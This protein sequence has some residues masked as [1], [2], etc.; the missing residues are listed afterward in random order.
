M[1]PNN[2]NHVQRLF[3]AMDRSWRKLRPWRENRERLIRKY[4]GSHYGYQNSGNIDSHGTHRRRKEI[5]ANLLNQTADAYMMALSANRPRVLVSTDFKELRSFKTTLQTAI[6]HLI[7]ELH[8]EDS[9][10]EIVLNSFFSIGVAKIYSRDIGPVQGAE[11]SW[12]DPGMPF[13][14]SLSLDDW[15]YDT[16]AARWNKIAFAADTYR[17]N[18]EGLLE[19]DRNDPKTVK[20][21]G[22]TTRFPQTHDGETP[23]RNLTTD[24]DSTDDDEIEP[25][26]F[27]MDVWLPENREVVTWACDEDH[28]FGHTVLRPLRVVPWDDGPEQ[29]PYRHLNLAS[30]V[31]DNVM[32]VSPAE[33]LSALH[34]LVNGLMLKSRKQA[35]NQKDVPVFSAGAKDDAGRVTSASDGEFTLVNN[36]LE[37]DVMKFNGADPGTQQFTLSMFDMFDR[38]A[39]NLSA[40]AGLGPQSGTVGQDQLIHAQVSRR[41]AKMQYQVVRFTSNVCTDLGSLLWHDPVREQPGSRRIDGVSFEIDDPWR[42]NERFGDFWQYNFAVEP[43]SMSYKSPTERVASINDL[44]TNIYIPAMQAGLM[45]GE[46]DMQKLLEIHA[47]LLDLPR[48]REIVKI[49]AA[50]LGNE[51]PAGEAPG[52]PVHTKREVI[53]RNIPTGGTDQSRRAELGKALLG[54]RGNDDQ[55]AAM[56]RSRA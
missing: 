5:I 16:Q 42:A 31:P 17:V 34:D 1:N 37:M 11:D 53:R 33:N 18:F 14:E 56:T 43:F 21:V 4:V 55:A 29:G 30:D 6:N 48:L 25:K 35:M 7:A 52:K 19:D 23:V 27:L 28:R 8:I 20:M 41:E 39:G 15:I 13:M 49:G 22:P 9:L 51:G 47:E 12:V 2:P 38:M 50:P 54:F 44:L 32:P 46:F 24:S 3:T 10:N 26:I 40:Q 45:Q 36:V